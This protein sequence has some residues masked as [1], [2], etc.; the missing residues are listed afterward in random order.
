[1][2][3]NNT[4]YILY[5]VLIVLGSSCS[6]M[7]TAPANM[8]VAEYY[9][10]KTGKYITYKLDSTVFVNLNT[11]R[12]VRT[13]IVQDIY[14]AFIK[15][16]VGRDALRIRRMIRS[17]TD[18]TK[19][20]DNATFTV[21]LTNDQR[22]EFSEN[23]IRF[24]KLINPVSL[25]STW[26]GN[27]HINVQDEFLRFYDNWDYSYENI[28][29][30]FTINNKTFPETIT[31]QQIDKTEGNPSNPASFYVKTKSNEVYAK[32]IGLIY[33]EFLH[34]FWQTNT[35]SFQSNSYGVRLS[36]L[37]HNF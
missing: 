26:K 4:I 37:N 33:K 28:N 32:G 9:P 12:V 7:D 6:K 2:K 3:R 31:V 35:A 18:T 14:D 30:P 13:Y 20:T 5:F 24:I 23:N 34:E 15:D 36:I 1:M 17:N 27:A 8:N 21:T 10:L 22:I 25:F 11:Q 16:N 19:W 29:E